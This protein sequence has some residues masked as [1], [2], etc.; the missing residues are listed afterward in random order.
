MKLPQSIKELKKTTKKDW[1][2]ASQKNNF[3][4][5]LIILLIVFLIIIGV[6]IVILTNP[7]QWNNFTGLFS[8]PSVSPTATPIPTPTPIELPRG[9]REFGASSKGV[10]PQF[11]DLKFSEYNPKIGEEQTISVSLLDTE[12]DVSE[13]NL[14]LI[15]DNKT[16]TY[17]MKLIEGTNK[18]GTWSVT[19]K[20]ED[21]H[22]YKYRLRIESR[23]DK[24]Q[25]SKVEPIFK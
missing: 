25:T 6:L 3:L 15:T 13:V 10:N 1:Q 22:D 5:Q 12:S 24:G 23:N 2:K 18:K 14:T 7:K 4:N 19:I 17:P 9:P 21:T 20:T 16:K 11:R 8:R